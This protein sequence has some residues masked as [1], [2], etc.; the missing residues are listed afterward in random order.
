VVRGFKARVTRAAGQA[1]WQRNFYEHV[2]RDEADLLRVRQY[3]DDNP[4]R[5]ALD[6]ENPVNNGAGE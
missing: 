1:L 5:W 3:I 6:R 2:V 4:L